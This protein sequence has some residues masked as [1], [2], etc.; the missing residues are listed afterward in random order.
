M[1]KGFLIAALLASVAALSWSG[2]WVLGRAIRADIPPFDLTFWR[3]TLAAIVLA[4]FAIPRL[5]AEWAAVRAGWVKLAALALTGAAA[6]Q[7][8]VYVGL[9]YTEAVNAL[10]L[11]TMAPL[12]VIPFAWVIL[13]ERLSGRQ[14]AGIALSLVGAVWLVMRGD[15]AALLTLSFNRGDLIILAALTIWGIYSVQLK[16]KPKGVSLVPLNFIISVFGAL[17]IA[18]LA[19]WEPTGIPLTPAGIFSVGYTGL[20]ASVIAFLAYAA[21]VERLGA[22]RT[23]YFLHLMPVFGSLLAVIFLGERIEVYHLIGFPVTLAGVLWATT[24]SRA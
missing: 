9:R 8:M 4:P 11:N 15:P 3:W 24:G 13:G 20:V 6:F 14:S 19:F 5:R 1:N 17:M 22:S 18:P 7:S 21:A 10:L 12:L 2:N 16:L 23:V